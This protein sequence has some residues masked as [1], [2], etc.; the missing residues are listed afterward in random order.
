MLRNFIKTFDF[1]TATSKKVLFEH[2]TIVSGM[3]IWANTDALT[4]ETTIK[5]MS[6]ILLDKIV[7]YGYTSSSY[8]LVQI[9]INNWFI[10]ANT[11]I[12]IIT[13][14]T[15]SHT[16]SLI[17]NKANGTEQRK[18]FRALQSPGTL[19]Y[20]EIRTTYKNFYLTDLF[21]CSLDDAGEEKA[22]IRINDEYFTNVGFNVANMDTRIIKLNKEEILPG[23]SIISI[24]DNTN[25]SVVFLGYELDEEN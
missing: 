6:N 4:F 9:P 2:D 24:Q 23:S 17:C 12:E 13:S 19:Y 16:I 21:L 7:F 1:A 8:T 22:N 3:N 14:T 18:T 15:G 20:R 5:Q 25:Y 10:P 11:E